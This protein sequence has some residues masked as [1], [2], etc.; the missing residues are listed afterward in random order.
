[1]TS[2]G[3]GVNEDTCFTLNAV[4]RHGVV[5][6]KESVDVNQRHES[7]GSGESSE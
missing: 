7:N 2:H 4:D 5:Y 1:M 6:R 3:S